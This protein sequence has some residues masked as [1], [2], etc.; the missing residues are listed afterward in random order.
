M[1]LAISAGFDPVWFGIF[2][3]LTVEMGQITPPV[4]FNLFVIQSL[5]GRSIGRVALYAAPF[6]LLMLVA[7]VLLTAFPEIALWLPGVLYD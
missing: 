4:G 2:L 3:I 5:T 1:P 7:I 6:F